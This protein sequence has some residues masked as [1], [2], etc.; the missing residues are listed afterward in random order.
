MNSTM[1]LAQ[2]MNLSRR[3]QCR[4]TMRCI[5]I[6]PTWHKV[7]VLVV[8]LLLMTI[9]VSG[10][11]NAGLENTAKVRK[12][13]SLTQHQLIP[14]PPSLCQFLEFD[15]HHH[16]PVGETNEFPDYVSQQKPTINNGMNP[17]KSYSK[18]IIM[19]KNISAGG[20]QIATV[21][22]TRVRIPFLI[23]AWILF[24]SLAKIGS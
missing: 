20:Y 24:A 4:G 10:R 3:Q 11:P 16:T 17:P 12:R 7:I 19:L 15:D 8:A 13:K 6:S 2:E 5:S 14:L 22:F 21:D 1:S 18:D 23:A 9:T